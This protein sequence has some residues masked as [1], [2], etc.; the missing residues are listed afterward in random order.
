MAHAAIVRRAIA[1]RKPTP[2]NELKRIIAKGG[3][4]ELNLQ[5]CI[6]LSFRYKIECLFIPT[7]EPSNKSKMNTMTQKRC[8]F[9][10]S[11]S[12]PATRCNSNMHGRRDLLDDIARNFT[13]QEAR[14]CFDSFHI[15]E[16]RYIA[17]TYHEH[18]RRVVFSRT[19]FDKPTIKRL[20][21]TIPAT[22]TKTRIVRELLNRWESYEPIRASLRE[23][24]EGDDCP[25]CMDAM[26]VWDWDRRRMIWESYTPPNNFDANYP[27][28]GHVV[29]KCGHKFCRGCWRL[30]LTS[31]AKCEYYHDD[32]WR[33][34]PVGRIYVACPL[35]RE[36][37]FIAARDQPPAV[38]P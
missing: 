34:T 13:L 23:K 33:H 15:N 12:H 30:H 8:V 5:L 27:N 37:L 16:L 3:C 25:I 14:P 28:A 22:L 38:G 11:A 20:K 35:C 29:T 21:A 24:P 4:A 17:L 9:C 2:I 31:N 7:G 10:N 18:H 26:I 36:R 1:K 19:Q 6:Q 32:D